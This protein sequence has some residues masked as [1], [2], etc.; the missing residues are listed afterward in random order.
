MIFI[1]FMSM[2][3]KTFS[4]TL[5]GTDTKYKPYR[6]ITSDINK[7]QLPYSAHEI[8]D[9]D[10]T[11]LRGD[12]LSHYHSCLKGVG[13]KYYYLSDKKEE[14]EYRKWINEQ[15]QSV[16]QQPEGKV[17]H[18]LIEGPDTAATAVYHRIAK[19]VME[20]LNAIMR[21]DETI[22]IAGHSRGCVE[23]ILVAQE[24]DRIKKSLHAAQKPLSR[25]TLLKLI[26]NSD[27]PKSTKIMIGAS[28]ALDKRKKDFIHES[29]ANPSTVENDIK[30]LCANMESV[31]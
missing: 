15:G 5:L 20:A 3:N 14:K 13:R 30:Q 25:D 6:D 8:Q 27:G 17:T 19:A 10:M 9:N 24:L 1:C 11:K 4:T 26:C 28:E 2:Q 16:E 31:R 29:F 18:C 23:S 21:G 22:N 7:D 12:T